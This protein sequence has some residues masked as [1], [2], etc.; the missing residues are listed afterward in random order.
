MDMEATE[1]NTAKDDSIV[2][3]AFK[4]GARYGA[5][6][7][8]LSTV[9]GYFAG[10]YGAILPLSAG[11]ACMQFGFGAYDEVKARKEGKGI[12]ENISEDIAEVTKANIP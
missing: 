2:K 9:F 6:T 11:V 3:A 4:K 1:E 12:V 10:D 7:A 5:F 8:V